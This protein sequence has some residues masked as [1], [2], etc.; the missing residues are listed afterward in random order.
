MIFF[1]FWQCR[2]IVAQMSDTRSDAWNHLIWMV[3]IVT[4]FSVTPFNK[5][6]LPTL[7]SDAEQVLLYFLISVTTLTHVHYGYSV[8]NQVYYF[9]FFAEIFLNTFFYILQQV[10]EM[11][12]HFKIRCFKVRLTTNDKQTHE[13]LN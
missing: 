4:S 3:L 6:G 1:I 8:V 10:C 2:L 11:C 5:I 9:F 13:K 12:D 7:S